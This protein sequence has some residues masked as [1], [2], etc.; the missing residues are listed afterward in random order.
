M[1]GS[2]DFMSGFMSHWMGDVRGIGRYISPS[3]WSV[4]SKDC[5]VEVPSAGADSDGQAHFFYGPCCDELTSFDIGGWL[6]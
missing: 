5:G 4:Q 1:L 6:A 2:S 3:E